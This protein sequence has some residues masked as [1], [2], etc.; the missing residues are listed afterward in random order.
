MFCIWKARDHVFNKQIRSNLRFGSNN[1]ALSVCD[2]GWS[3]CIKWRQD[4]K[5]RIGKGHR[6]PLVLQRSWCTKISGHNTFWSQCFY[7]LQSPY[8]W[9]LSITVG[10]GTH[11]EKKVCIDRYSNIKILKAFVSHAWSFMEN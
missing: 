4:A 6:L 9:T 8:I 10:G 7:P 3:R 5:E 1:Q 11:I 2:D